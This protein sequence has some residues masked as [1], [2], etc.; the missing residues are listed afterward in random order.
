MKTIYIVTGA[1]GF[2]GNVVVRKLI[3]EKKTVR[4][5]V[6]KGD[7]LKSLEGLDCEIFYG[8]TT[9]KES[10]KEI[11]DVKDKLIV[12]HCAGIVS[13]VSKFDQRVFDVNVMGT[14]NV[15]DMCIEKKVEKLIHVSSVHAIPEV[16]N[17]GLIKEVN[18]F[19][20]TLVEGL[21]AKTKAEASAYVMAKIN[22]GLNAVIVHPSGIIG[23]YDFGDSHLT[24]MI[25]DCARG[26]LTAAVHG[27]YDFVDV[28]D[29]A[30]GIILAANNKSSR[31][32]YILSNKYF[33][34]IDILNITSKVLNKKGIKTILPMWFARFTAPL[35]ELYY[36]ILKQ[37][38]L[39]TKYSLF[40]LYANGNFDNSKAKKELGYTNRDINETIKDTLDWLKTQNRI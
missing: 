30:N 32:C 27:G 26:K 5:L 25:E 22:E 11:F 31:G 12:I 19:D 14:K 16:V 1:N 2:L 20:K 9:N 23:P 3:E 40:T 7:R 17:K 35:S 21:Y 18:H 34:V 29:V 15:V 8:D 13:I 39:Y 10:L 37:T 24:K 33:E 38:P 36:R 4:C 6:L 28:R